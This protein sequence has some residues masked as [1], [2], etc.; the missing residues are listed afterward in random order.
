[1]LI[2]RSLTW[3]MYYDGWCPKCGCVTEKKRIHTGMPGIACRQCT[4][5]QGYSQV[6]FLEDGNDLL[7]C[8]DDFI[9]PKGK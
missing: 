2:S 8:P 9:L 3:D 6:N 4:K 5:C 1:M 7:E